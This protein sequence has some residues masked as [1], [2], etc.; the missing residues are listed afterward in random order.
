M[1]KFYSRLILVLGLGLLYLSIKKDPDH[2]L[3]TLL[4]T[5]FGVVVFVLFFYIRKKRCH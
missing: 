2:W 3:S 5:F 1:K 4:I